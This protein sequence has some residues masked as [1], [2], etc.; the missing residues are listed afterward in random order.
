MQQQRDREVPEWAICPITHE[1]MVDPVEAADRRCYERAAILGLMEGKPQGSVKIPGRES[2]FKNHDL[3]APAFNILAAIAWVRSEFALDRSLD[4]V[5]T[6]V[7]EA[8]PFNFDGLPR[9][10]QHLIIKEY[11]QRLTLTDKKGLAELGNIELL[12][13]FKP[14][15]KLA[16]AEFKDFLNPILRAEPREVRG[17]LSARPDLVPAK[18][19]AI[20]KLLIHV[21][22]GEIDEVEEM[23]EQNP[24]LLLAK[25]RVMDFSERTFFG[26]GISAY[27]YARAAQDEEMV[28][29]LM[30]YFPKGKKA[31]SQLHSR[32]QSFKRC[33]RMRRQKTIRR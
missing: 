22:K 5:P 9:D 10:V 26:K 8:G 27:Q 15:I 31:K 12:Q 14:A 2:T 21:V 25:G 13:F 29:M 1:I 19:I 3:R 33:S 18:E 16:T 4:V 20:T 7:K 28:K 11:L 24:E 32:M 6:D 17:M 23:L 30:H